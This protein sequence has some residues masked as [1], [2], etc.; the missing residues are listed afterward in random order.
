MCHTP[1]GP[2]GPDMARAFAGGNPME[3]PPMFGT[4]TL[5]PSNITSDKATGIGSWSEA[6]L[7]K[8]VKTATRPDG[9]PIQGPM[10]FYTHGWSQLTDEDAQALAAFVKSIPPVANKVPASTFKPAGP[11]G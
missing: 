10:Q 11:P 8:A 6:D 5:H 9:R 4:G 3:L 1:M 2:Q 7:I